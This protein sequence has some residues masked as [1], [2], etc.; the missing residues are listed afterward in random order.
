MS[1]RQ[2]RKTLFL[3]LSILLFTSG[4]VGGQR[5]VGPV[6]TKR[7]RFERGRTTAI[8]KG[9]ARTPGTYEYLLRVRSGQTMT[10]HLTSSNNGVEFSVETPNGDWAESALGVTD[11]SGELEYSG[12]YRILVTNNRSKVQR[13]PRYALEVTVR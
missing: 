4:T 9:I 5:F 1:S 2:L 8:I 6:I 10:V 3:L 12:D 13:N 7:V 11:W